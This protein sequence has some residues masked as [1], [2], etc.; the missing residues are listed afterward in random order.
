MITVDT[1]HHLAHSLRQLEIDVE[2]R[3]DTDHGPRWPPASRC[4][5]LTIEGPGGHDSMVV[6][7]TFISTHVPDAEVISPL[8]IGRTTF[9]GQVRIWPGTVG[10]GPR[11]TGEIATG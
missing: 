3:V 5:L 2:V 4:R 6:A 10:G 11:I 8:E 7:M 9:R 1:I